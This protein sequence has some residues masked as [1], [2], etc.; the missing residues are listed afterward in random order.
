MPIPELRVEA[1]KYKDE[2]YKAMKLRFGWGPLDKVRG[3]D[4]KECGVD[5]RMCAR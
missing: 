4:A 1:K 5:S 3:G 2:G